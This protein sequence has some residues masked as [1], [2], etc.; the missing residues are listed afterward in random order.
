[1]LLFREFDND[2]QGSLGFTQFAALLNRADRESRGVGSSPMRRV[3]HSPLKQPQPQQQQPQPQ[4]QQAQQPGGTSGGTGGAATDVDGGGGDDLFSS[5]RRA[6]TSLGSL[7]KEVGRAAL[8]VGRALGFDDDV[9]P[10]PAAA[11]PAVPRNTGMGRAR[12]RK[13]SAIVAA[14]SEQYL[15]LSHVK[16]LFK[17][18]N[19]SSQVVPPLPHPMSHLRRCSLLP[20]HI[21]FHLIGQPPELAGAR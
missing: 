11:P 9:A 19:L 17:A 3:S 1:M 21:S 4:P 12:W 14:A 2:S 20:S 15:P 16:D 18:A 10:P 5:L 8:E 7:G 13:A 6:G